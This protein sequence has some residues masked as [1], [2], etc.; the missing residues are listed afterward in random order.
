MWKMWGEEFAGCGQGAVKQRVVSC[1][2]GNRQMQQSIVSAGECRAVMLARSLF[3]ER[4]GVVVW[5]WSLE[6][7]GT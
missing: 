4:E 1:G 2:R 6:E 5:A 7:A 3:L